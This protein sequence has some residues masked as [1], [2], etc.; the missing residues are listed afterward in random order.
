[1][2]DVMLIRKKKTEKLEKKPAA[3]RHPEIGT[4]WFPGQGG[5]G[6]MAPDSARQ[7][8]ETGNDGVTRPVA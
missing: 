6:W 8:F 1:V 7:I 3:V 4:G 5:A 2:E